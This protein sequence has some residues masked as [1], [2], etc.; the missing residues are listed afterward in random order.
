MLMT[1]DI[2]Q[3]LLKSAKGYSYTEMTV[4]KNKYGQRTRK[5][6]RVVP[7]NVWAIKFLY[8]LQKTAEAE[9]NEALFSPQMINFLSYNNWL[10]DDKA[11]HKFFS[12]LRQ[13]QGRI[14][15][16]CIKNN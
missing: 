16:T 9:K 10:D 15:R 11:R 5:I 1:E 13:E 7:P 4:M 3:S 2:K 12:D 6:L 14:N 8:E